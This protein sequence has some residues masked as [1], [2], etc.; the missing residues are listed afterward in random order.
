MS[1]QPFMLA[2][3]WIEVRDG[4]DS[5]RDI[6]D[7]HYSRRVYADGRKPK[8]FIGPGEKMPLLRHDASALFVWRKFKSGDDQTG[9][10]CA[11]FRN[12]DSGELASA[13]ITSAMLIAWGR[14]PGERFFTYVNPR[15]VKPTMVR[16]YPVWGFCF[17]KAGWKF[18]RLTKGGLHILAYERG[19]ATPATPPPGAK[20]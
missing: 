19:D 12:E 9:V 10:N 13:L 16:G 15:K 3:G 7:R 18:V 20:P 1:V 4:D 5:C 8:L 6:F 11:V 17:Y 14:W 2:E